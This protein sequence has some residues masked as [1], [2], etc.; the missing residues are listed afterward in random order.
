M[1][2]LLGRYHQLVENGELRPDP[3]QLAAAQRLGNLQ[4]QL[5]RSPSLGNVYRERLQWCK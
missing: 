4:H 3:E 1:T 2:G 5:E